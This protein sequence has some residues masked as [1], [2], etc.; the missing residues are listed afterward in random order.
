M[1]KKDNA[2]AV[3]KAPLREGEVEIKLLKDHGNCKKGATRRMPEDQANVL[4]NAG[5]AKAV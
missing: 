5:F 3:E 2:V 1:S 4:I